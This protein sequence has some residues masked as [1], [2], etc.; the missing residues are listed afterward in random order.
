MDQ[1]IRK[2]PTG[3]FRVIGLDNPR[4]RGWRQGDYPTFL[5]AKEAS[6]NTNGRSTICYRVYNDQ[7]ECVHGNGFQHDR[8]S[9]KK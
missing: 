8:A 6:L 3:Q 9:R 7:G 1:D 2:A 4:D 5:K